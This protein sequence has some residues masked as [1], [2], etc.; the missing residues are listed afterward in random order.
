MKF[1]EKRLSRK[2]HMQ[3]QQIGTQDIP[4][5]ILTKKE[6]MTATGSQGYQWKG[7]K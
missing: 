1:Q 2:S 5:L 6:D 7:L 4:L 3:A